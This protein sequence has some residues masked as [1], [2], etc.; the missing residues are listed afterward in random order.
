MTAGAVGVPGAFSFGLD[1]SVMAGI[2]STML[3]EIAKRSGRKV[4]QDFGVKL[5]TGV[6]AGVAAYVGGSKLA[7]KLLHLIPGAGT[8]AA[9]GVN[10][11]LNLFF[12]WRFGNAM[13][14]LFERGAFDAEDFGDI[15][16]YTLAILTPF[17]TPGALGE[18]V[19]VAE[20]EC[21]NGTP[22]A[23]G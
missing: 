10:S 3:M 5:V 2:W 23:A 11:L 6:L 14:K 19:S 1:V 18:M 9:I 16:A 4:S 7:M 8:L 21:P 20:G 13:A 22:S 12:T 17:P 15:V